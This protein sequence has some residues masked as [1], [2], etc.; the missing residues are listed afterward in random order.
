MVN[1]RKCLLYLL[2]CDVCFSLMI[3]ASRAVSNSMLTHS[4]TL[5]C[6]SLVTITS[7]KTR[8]LRFRLSPV[9]VSSSSWTLKPHNQN[10]GCYDN[11]SV[12]GPT[13]PLLVVDQESR[14]YTWA[15][16]PYMHRSH[17]PRITLC[18][19]PS[20]LSAPLLPVVYSYKAST[21]T[22]MLLRAEKVSF[23]DLRCI[24]LVHF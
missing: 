4:N 20:A 7:V 8:C 10:T 14:K 13:F 16:F 24:K 18:H 9:V 11:V 17:E 6:A 22:R 5:R 15:Q 12:R 3:W 21:S 1:F 23:N 2:Y 19:C